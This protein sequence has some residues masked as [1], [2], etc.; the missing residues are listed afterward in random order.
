MPKDIMIIYKGG[1]SKFTGRK[2]ERINYEPNLSLDV[3]ISR[4]CEKYNFSEDNHIINRR[5]VLLMLNGKFIPTV[6]A[7][8]I[9]L[10]QGDEITL[11]PTV[12][13]G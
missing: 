13:G 8:N 6:E 7:E 5:A 11:F 4:I 12:S 3:V 9:K 1:I 2:E 10:S